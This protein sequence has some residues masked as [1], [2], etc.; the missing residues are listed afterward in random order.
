LT[1]AWRNDYRSWGRVIRASHQVIRPSTRDEAALSLTAQPA[2]SVSYPKPAPNPPPASHAAPQP[3]LARGCGRS[4]GDVGLNQNGRL[5]DC[6]GL[7]RFIAFDRTTGILSCEAGVTLADILAVACRPDA[8]GSGWMLPVTPGTRFVTVGGAIANDVHG[9]NHHAFGTFGSHVLSLELARTDGSRLACTPTNHPDLFAATI[10]GLGLTGLI[11]SATIQLRRVHGLA[12]EAEDIRF[13]R[14]ADFFDLAAASDA[15]WEYTAAWIDCIA[16]GR[17][18][19]RGIY[20]RA[21]HVAGRGVEPPPLR[22]R[23]RL[24]VDLPFALVSPLTVRPFNAAYWRKSGMRRRATRIGSYEKVF[25]PLDAIGE[26]NRV[27]GPGG[28]YQF[29]CQ[30]PPNV[31]RDVVAELLRVAAT[32]GQAS[33]LSVLKLFGPK[34]SPGMLSFPAPGATLALDFPNRGTSTQALL[35]ELEQLV[36]QAGGRLYPAKDGLMHAETFHA[37]YQSVARFLPHIDHGFASGFA[38]R[39]ALIAEQG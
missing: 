24:A 6:T 28:F 19:G 15:D 27:Y 35:R 20:S 18:L 25:Y 36:V 17:S 7:D 9:K 3:V 23:L 29:Q 21:R 31:M 37:G 8:D 38:R 13:D 4:Y 22:P 39:V 14:L 34:D 30:I 1:T 5:I 10:A 33:M 16:S 11:L 12:V 26:W 32:S 2:P